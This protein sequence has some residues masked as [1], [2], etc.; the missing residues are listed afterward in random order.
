MESREEEHRCRRAIEY[1][2]TACYHREQASKHALKGVLDL[3]K[4]SLSRAEKYDKYAA[5][6]LKDLPAERVEAHMKNIKKGQKE[7]KKVEDERIKRKMEKHAASSSGVTMLK[8]TIP[9]GLIEGQ[10]FV[11]NYKGSNVYL[12]VPKGKISGDDLILG[13]PVEAA[14]VSLVEVNIKTGMPNNSTKEGYLEKTGYFNTAYKKRFFRLFE[15]GKLQYFE[16]EKSDKAN[17]ELDLKNT[18]MNT[19]PYE[20]GENHFILEFGKLTTREMRIK[21]K[22]QEDLKEWLETLKSHKSNGFRW[23]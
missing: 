11:A 2:E 21:A 12:V 5:D 8:A 9:D 1:Q 17:G 7:R 19:V 3:V 16:D 10:T 6:E 14:E 18:V 13:L 23:K 22:T 15:D 20:N 4:E